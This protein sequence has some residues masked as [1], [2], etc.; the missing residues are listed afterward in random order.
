MTQ[1]NE[2]HNHCELV[3]SSD[4]VVRK[5]ATGARGGK[6]PWRKP[7]LVTKPLGETALDGSAEVD[8]VDMGDFTAS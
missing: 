7:K 4:C 5:P 8:F 6:R 2:S 3:S 1:G